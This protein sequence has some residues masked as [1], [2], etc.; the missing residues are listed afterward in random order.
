[1][2]HGPDLQAGGQRIGYPGHG[3]AH[4]REQRQGGDRGRTQ[5]A[6]ERTD[7]LPGQPVALWFN[8]ATHAEQW[9][10]RAT[11]EQFGVEGVVAYYSIDNA[12][13]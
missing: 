13:S 12:L 10:L 8:P 5:D 11:G 1:M 4:H 3:P 2:R 6:A 9:L 7:R